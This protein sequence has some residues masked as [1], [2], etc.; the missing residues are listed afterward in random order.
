MHTE[1]ITKHWS[2]RH[3]LVGGMVTHY[4]IVQ[5]HVVKWRTSVAPMSTG[6]AGGTSLIRHMFEIL[7][8]WSSGNSLLEH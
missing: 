5:P 7:L 4:L 1:H 8:I 2:G 3:R 6:H